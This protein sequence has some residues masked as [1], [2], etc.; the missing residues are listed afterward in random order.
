MNRARSYHVVACL[1]EEKDEGEVDIGEA[2]KVW[3]SRR[4]VVV[5][6][7][8]A[9]GWGNGGERNGDLF[10]FLDTK[11]EVRGCVGSGRLLSLLPEP[12]RV[13]F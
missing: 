9:P 4:C 6:R 3:W 11:T 8:A 10:F 2:T 1:E 7:G 12:T 5:R 13:F